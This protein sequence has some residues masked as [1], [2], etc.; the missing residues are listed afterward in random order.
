MQQLDTSVS[1][2][3]PQAA[4]PVAFRAADE[5]PGPAGAA[6][7]PMSPPPP[8]GRPGC[9][10]RLIATKARAARCRISSSSS[11]A[12]ALPDAIRAYPP[13]GRSTP[14]RVPAPQGRRATL[15]R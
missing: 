14:N 1:G 2:G 7:A 15:S 11:T 13:G 9:R 6:L 8:A 5:Q 12:H 3:G 4:C 10:D